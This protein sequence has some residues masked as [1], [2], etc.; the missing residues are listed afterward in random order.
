MA[1]HFQAYLKTLKFAT[2]QAKIS[3][4]NNDKLSNQLN[5]NEKQVKVKIYRFCQKPVY[6]YLQQMIENDFSSN[7][8]KVKSKSLAIGTLRYPSEPHRQGNPQETA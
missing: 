3:C 6:T 7:I 1:C 8:N 2:K 5:P 4:I